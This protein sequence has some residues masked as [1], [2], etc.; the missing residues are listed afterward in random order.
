METEDDAMGMRRPDSSDDLGSI[1]ETLAILS[2]PLAMEQV[3]LRA[4]RRA[5]L[6][7][8]APCSPSFRRGS[9]VGWGEAKA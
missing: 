5:S 9:S 2:D 7:S 3:R 4:S 6:A 1:Q 8:R